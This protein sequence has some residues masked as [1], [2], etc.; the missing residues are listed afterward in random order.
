MLAYCRADGG[1]SN[2]A[3]VGGAVVGIITTHEQW[4]Q[5]RLQGIGA[6]EASAIIGLNPY[7]SN[8]DLWEIKTG[9]QKSPDI[10]SNAHVA[11]GH[12]AEGPLR[13]LFALDYPKYEVTYGGAFDMVRNEEY[14]FIFATLDGRLIEKDTGRRGV[15]EGKT[16]EILKSMSYEKWKGQVPDNYYVQLL[17][18]LLATGWEFAVL[19]AQL[20]RTYGDDVRTETR[21]FFL[22]RAEVQSDLDFLLEKELKFWEYVKGDERPPLVL[23]NIF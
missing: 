16:T 21:R 13:E 15:Y 22:E 20:K 6:S 18:Q 9:R 8:V 3:G 4:L 5:V 2:P 14:P 12:A 23:P 7:M 19:N 1:C 11:Y 10:S 17:H